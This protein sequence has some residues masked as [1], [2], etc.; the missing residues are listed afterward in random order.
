MRTLLTLLAFVALAATWPAQPPTYTL[1]PDSRLWIEGTSTLHDWTCEAE[2]LAGQIRFDDATQ[3]ALATTVTVP[4]D[5]LECKNGTM[6]RKMRDALQADAH[7][8]VRFVLLEATSTADEDGTF[9]LAAT[10]ELTVAGTTQPIAM[11][12]EGTVQDDDTVRFTGSY[13]MQMSDFGVDPPSA[14]L[15]T[16]KTGDAITV[17]FDVTA[18]P[19][20]QAAN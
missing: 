11:T 1:A 19:S 13:P 20:P 15:G 14:M 7:P 4:V 10:G 9:T 3:R 17:Y 16:L 2:R 12:V 5:Q 6:N 18:T 8:S